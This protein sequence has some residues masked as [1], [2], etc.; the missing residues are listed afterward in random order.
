MGCGSRLATGHESHDTTVETAAPTNA[1]VQDDSSILLAESE[2]GD[3]PEPS[4]PS[5]AVDTL[6]ET[7]LPELTEPEVAEAPAANEE[8]AAVPPEE[9]L[10]W[11][12]DDSLVKPVENEDS[13]SGATVQ[14]AMKDVPDSQIPQDAVV[15]EDRTEGLDWDEMGVGQEPEIKVGMPFKEIEP[16]RVVTDE[17]DFATDVVI[18]HLFPEGRDDETREAVSHLFPEGRGVTSKDFIDVVVGTP[19]KVSVATPMVELDT[20]S[21][22]SC[23]VSLSG[24]EFEYPDYV[25]DSM[26]KARLEDGDAKL[27]EKEYE[28]AIEA[29]EKAKTLYER[30]G[31]QKMVEECTKRT[32]LGYDAMANN[33]FEQEENHQKAREYEWAIVQYRKARELYMFSTDSKKRARCAAKVR[34]CYVEW[35]KS[36][37]S[38]GDA[39]AKS[40]NTREALANYQEAAEKYRQADEKKR[41]KGLD[42]KIRKA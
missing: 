5:D 23:G 27:K 20:P 34:E 12:V 4:V 31:N 17:I 3:I 28:H 2:L 25:Y 30:A 38:E 10:S 6:P 15:L 33:H 21:C 36:L 9:D 7:E 1:E 37:E 39:L 14:A 11:E 41:L 22:P 40:G 26:G 19:T 42:K 29:F 13:S 8:A 35:G 24:D 18:D 32:D 16:P